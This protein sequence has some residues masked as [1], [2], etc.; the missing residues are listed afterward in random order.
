MHPAPDQ[1][2][3][4]G[5]QPVAL[6]ADALRAL[7][8]IRHGFFTRQGGVS[9]GLYAS[10]NVGLASRDDLTKVR[11]NRAR[12]MRALGLPAKAL[13]AGYQVHGVDVATVDGPWPHG[14]LPRV[15]GLVTNRR[16]IALGCPT[17]DCAPVL[18]ADRNAG[19]IGTAHAGWKG[20][21]AGILA[22]TVA[23]MVRLGARPSDIV[24]AIG[25]CI[26]QPSYEVGPEFPVPFTAEDP[27]NRDLFMPSPRAGHFLFDLSGYVER[28]L[29]Q[30]DLYA[31]DR[32][33]CDTAADEAR[34]FSYRRATLRGEPAFGLMLSTIALV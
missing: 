19:V 6:T 22:A 11:E 16:G 34:F 20:A 30:L 33:N 24:A 4:D 31:V 9:D 2:D 23:A 21:L 27:R 5:T 32:L 7:P 14:E 26:A 8:G 3:A 13:V 29:G 17:A 10:L 18:F 25:P 1:N 12:A 28:K 15:D